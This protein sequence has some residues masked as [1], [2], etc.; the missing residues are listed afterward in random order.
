V[1]I[2]NLTLALLIG[3]ALVIVVIGAFLYEW[4]VAFISLLAIP[5]SLVA[6]G[7]VLY[8]QGA[9]INT[10]VLAGFVVALGSVVDDAIIDVENIVRRLRQNRKE[11]G[12]RS[13]GSII[14]EASLEIRSAIVFAT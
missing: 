4:R 1:S 13:T 9:T 6:A 12:G 11:G 2:N 7:L 8:Y 10:M 3:A 5:L 14:L